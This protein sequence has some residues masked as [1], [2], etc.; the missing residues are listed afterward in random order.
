MA[1]EPRSIATAHQAGLIQLS[2][3]M[4]LEQLFVAIASNCLTQIIDNSV[5]LAQSYD[6]ETVHQ[7]RVGLRRLRVA[8]GLCKD[9]LKLPLVLQQELDWLNAELSAARDWDVLAETTLPNMAAKLPELLQQM[10]KLSAVKRAVLSRAR[11]QHKIALTAVRSKRGV[12]LM[13]QL[14]S[15]LAVSGWHDKLSA[16]N[17]KRLLQPSTKFT[18]N[19]L[20]Q[21]QH[22]LV[23]RCKNLVN[24]SAHDIH[25][26]RIAAKKLRYASE[27]FQSLYARKLIRKNIAGLSKL[28]Q[29]LGKMNDIAVANELLQQLQHQQPALAAS[30]HLMR[31][32]I[33]LSA[34]GETKKTSA[35]LKKYRRF[36]LAI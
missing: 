11:Q 8:L 23:K 22:R 5:A 36:K 1:I 26:V 14:I 27:F 4:N 18:R 35:W 9:V 6:A 20:R 15:W 2:L 16:K 29:K 3:Q 30:M 24:A 34:K 10:I 32:Y 7:L 13:Q 17:Y 12:S 31:A 21:Q 25:R 28:Q 33:Q 19:S